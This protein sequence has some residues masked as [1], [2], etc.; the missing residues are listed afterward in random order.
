MAESQAL[1]ERGRLLMQQGSGEAAI[2]A[3]SRAVAK[4]PESMDYSL[5]LARAYAATGRERDAERLLRLLAARHDGPE[6]RVE[7]AAAL[8]RLDRPREAAEVLREVETRLDAAG[9]RLYAAVLEQSGGRAQAEAACARILAT[10]RGNETVRLYG[11]DLAL[12]DQRFT[13]ALERIDEARRAGPDSPGLCLRAAAAYL[14]L[15][16]VLGDA[17]VRRGPPDGAGRFDGDW[18]LLEP[19]SRPSEY[20]ACPRGSAMYQ[21]RLALDGG[22]D[23]P[24]AHLLHARLW[25]RIGRPETALR[26]LQARAP[27]LLEPPGDAGSN[28]PLSC[29]AIDPLTAFCEATLEAGAL[30]EFLRFAR[31]RYQRTRPQDA[32]AA[33]NR[34]ADDYAEAARRFAQRGDGRLAGALLRRACDLAPRNAQLWE[35]LSDALWLDGR[36][37]AAAG[38]YRKVLAL[39]PAHARRA[40]MLE[41][42]AAGEAAAA[43]GLDDLPA[44]APAA[45]P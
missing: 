18:L 37:V 35:Q 25:Q 23:S 12:C 32:P 11:I 31:L 44:G 17:Q 1:F 5:A 33:A 14:G 41:R 7:L 3:L 9:F 39:Q 30:D 43:D 36:P 24:A 10:D 22:I 20:L 34:L 21:I 28:A 27:L 4:A 16:R 19:R 42:V 2:D 13:V 8:R 26:V 45:E 38:A 29:M 15:D 40:E 6:V